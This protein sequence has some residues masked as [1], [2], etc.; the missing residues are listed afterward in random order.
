MLLILSERI[1]GAEHRH[2]HRLGS[3]S[4]GGHK[5]LRVYPIGYSLFRGTIFKGVY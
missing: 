4:R 5:R 3:A 2:D 1:V